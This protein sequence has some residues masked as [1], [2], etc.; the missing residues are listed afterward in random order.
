M[1][2]WR[3]GDQWSRDRHR[4]GGEQKDHKGSRPYVVCSQCSGWAFVDRKLAK[5]KL[6]NSDFVYKRA[7]GKGKGS[8]AASHGAQT[9]RDMG[10]V[11]RAIRDM[12]SKDPGLSALAHSFEEIARP[13]DSIAPQPAPAVDSEG[14][15]QSSAQ[16][17][18]ASVLFKKMEQQSIAIAKKVED[19]A[20]ELERVHQQMADSETKLQEARA[21]HTAEIS[22]HL[23]AFPK[24]CPVGASRLQATEPAAGADPPSGSDG[25]DEPADV[26]TIRAKAQS[27]K[28]AL[29]EEEAALERAIRETNSGKKRKTDDK[30]TK[31]DIEAAAADAAMG[32][33]EQLG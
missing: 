18:K 13:F 5:C 23:A 16:V 32:A 21:S 14:F 20:A 12:L 3:S 15:K 24:G 19:A 33:A 27:L 7:A 28:Q 26:D 1:G 10:M 2:G 31:D 4:Y 29:A 30:D 25:Y 11:L 9:D 8:G 22:R 17:Q 6:C